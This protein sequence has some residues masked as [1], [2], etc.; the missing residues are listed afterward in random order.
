MR[1]RQKSIHSHLIEEFLL[2]QSKDNPH[3]NESYNFM[4]IESVYA[5][6]LTIYIKAKMRC[7]SQQEKKAK[8][9]NES[10]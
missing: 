4:T 1:C 2:L 6:H 9:A 5:S 8:A 3:P 7:L 10:R